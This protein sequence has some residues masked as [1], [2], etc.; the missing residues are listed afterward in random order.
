MK[1]NFLPQ[2]G[3]FPDVRDQRS[4]PGR[5]LQL[6]Q[7]HRFFEVKTYKWVLIKGAQMPNDIVDKQIKSTIDAQLLMKGLT[8]VDTDERQISSSAISPPSGQ[9]SNSPPSAAGGQVGAMVGAGMA[10]DGTVEAE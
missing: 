1:K 6:R 3:A 5:P 7:G 8:A 10:E 4:L 9:R 2:P